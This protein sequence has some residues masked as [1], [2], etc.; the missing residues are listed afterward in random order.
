MPNIIQGDLTAPNGRFAIV[1]ARF[2]EFIVDQLVSGAVAG[3]KRHGVADDA[4]DVIR[5]IGRAHV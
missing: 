4:V 1:A 3:L 2:N 5:E